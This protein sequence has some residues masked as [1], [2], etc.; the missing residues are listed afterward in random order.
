MKIN[1]EA[2]SLAPWVVYKNNILLSSKLNAIKVPHVNFEQ[3]PSDKLEYLI[4]HGY[5]VNFQPQ[6]K[7][8]LLEIKNSHTP[9][10][11]I[12]VIEDSFL[13]VAQILKNELNL[14]DFGFRWEITTHTENILE[15]LKHNPAQKPFILRLSHHELI[16][17]KAI[18]N[19]YSSFF[20]KAHIIWIGETIEGTHVGPVISTTCD[21]DNYLLATKLWHFSKALI[22]AGFNEYWPCSIYRNLLSNPTGLAKAILQITQAPKHTCFLL[23][24]EKEVSLW[25]T[26]IEQKISEVAF[27]KTQFWSKGLIRNFQIQEFDSIPGGYIAQ[28]R[29]P[30]EGVDYLEGNSGKGI[31][32]KSA[33]YSLVGESIERFS[34][35]Q[36]NKI[37][38]SPPSI[39]EQ[40]IIY[41]VDQFHPFG[42]KWEEYLNS[43]EIVLPLCEVRNEINPEQLHLVPECLISFPYESPSSEYQVTTS[44]TAGLA[45]YS[46]YTTAVVK[47]AL[48]LF[49]RNDFYPSFLF[50]KNGFKLDFSKVYLSENT[51]LHNFTLLLKQLEKNQ[52]CYWCI[53]Y[54]LNTRFA[55]VH[56]LILDENNGFFSRGSGSGRTLIEATANSLVEALQIRYEFLRMPENQSGFQGYH[57]WRMPN[58]VEQIKNYLEKFQNMPFLDHPLSKIEYN[59]AL[60][61]AEIK[62]SLKKE[63]KPLLVANLPCPILDWSAVRVLIPGFTT[64]QYPS[65]SLGGQKIINPIFKYSIPS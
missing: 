60:L 43:P 52:L 13:E 3:I 46:D 25:T 10:N 55:I 33:T 20:D 18:E 29:T 4:N 40:H 50:K 61:L 53:V 2:L 14:L 64:H 15:S 26:L 34:A 19:L 27:F 51:P 23:E 12:W 7:N 39:T 32:L 28:S 37:T 58:V 5:I 57:H 56:T 45:V 65:Q 49:E 35:W 42:P 47:G 62:D 24:D 6:V 22:E 11:W 44:S 41:N 38:K 8:H 17:K 36:Q 31:D 9:S 48:E 59:S 21:L 63:E 30:C 16:E 1:N 54:N